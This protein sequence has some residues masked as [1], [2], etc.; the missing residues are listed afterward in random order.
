MTCWSAGFSRL[1]PGLEQGVG[2]TKERS[3]DVPAAII[4]WRSQQSRSGASLDPAYMSCFSTGCKLF[5][6][7]MFKE[8]S[9]FINRT[10]GAAGYSEK[11]N[12][13]TYASDFEIQFYS[14]D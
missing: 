13:K 11:H 2:R 12:F 1:C 3:G 8:L 7:A 5:A 10:S 6:R 14:R 4:S 9:Q